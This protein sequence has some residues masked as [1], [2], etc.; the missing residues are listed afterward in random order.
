MMS[1][2]YQ[3]ILSAVNLEEIKTLLMEQ[4]VNEDDSDSVAKLVAFIIQA[5]IPE[6]QKQ[7]IIQS[8]IGIMMNK[9]LVT[10]DGFHDFIRTFPF[11]Y[12]LLF[13][14]AIKGQAEITET[15]LQMCGVRKDTNPKVRGEILSELAIFDLIENLSN[16]YAA[17]YAHH[18][19]PG[20]YE[21]RS[22]N[23]S[24][25][26]S[27]QYLIST[28]FS[29]LPR[30]SLEQGRRTIM[31]AM[32]C[33]VDNDTQQLLPILM[34][35]AGV[36][37]IEKTML[38][39]RASAD[40]FKKADF[41]PNKAFTDYV[42]SILMQILNNNDEDRIGNPDRVLFAAKIA[43]AFDLTQDSF[44]KISLARSIT[45]IAKS[46]GLEVAQ[47]TALS[48]FKLTNLTLT[49]LMVH[50][51]SIYGRIFADLNKLIIQPQVG[52]TSILEGLCA[53][54]DE[55]HE[56]VLNQDI[57]KKL[58]LIAV[59]LAGLGHVDLAQK[60]ITKFA[61]NIEEISKEQLPQ[62]IAICL[63]NG[64]KELAKQITDSFNVSQLQISIQR[65]F[66][67]CNI[68]YYNYI[69][70]PDLHISLDPFEAMV[71]FL[72]N[73]E[74]GFHSFADDDRF[75]R[76][77]DELIAYIEA[78]DS[79][80]EPINPGDNE[81]KKKLS[82]I[83]LVFIK[84]NRLDLA[85]KMIQ[86]SGL[87]MVDVLLSQKQEDQ[88]EYRRKAYPEML[89][90][91]LIKLGRTELA[92]EIMQ[93]LNITVNECLEN[94]MLGAGLD[95]YH[96]TFGYYTN[97]DNEILDSWV[98]CMDTLLK[99]P[100]NTDQKIEMG[101]ENGTGIQR[102]AE[103][104]KAKNRLDLV[105]KILNIFDATK[106]QGQPMYV[107]GNIMKPYYEKKKLQDDHKKDLHAHQLEQ[108]RLAAS[109]KFADVH[110]INAG[111]VIEKFEQ[112]V[113]LFFKHLS[114]NI[115]SNALQNEANMK[116]LIKQVDVFKDFIS[117]YNASFKNFASNPE[118]LK[119]IIDQSKLTGKT[120]MIVLDSSDEFNKDSRSILIV[121]PK[122]DNKY[123]AWYFNS[124]GLQMPDS[125]KKI[126]KECF[127]ESCTTNEVT[128]PKKDTKPK[129]PGSSGGA[130][131]SDGGD[132][133]EWERNAIAQETEA[134]K[135]DI[136]A[137]KQG[138]Q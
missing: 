23:E 126:I 117:H 16:A 59:S 94:I 65:L 127:G 43:A 93:K 134:H 83:A 90:L 39:L 62:C 21:R 40:R 77:S 108:Q 41:D 128:L 125:V 2:I 31:Q 14:S 45:F 121:E 27:L 19:H 114:E 75:K 15:L 28:I 53:A 95:K 69:A 136:I 35:M 85:D 118:S 4:G 61:L 116:S 72:G 60:L 18:E 55:N 131:A 56:Q 104:C 100:H 98:Y 8:A 49:D 129:K 17:N 34:Q 6:K 44:V 5:D 66:L 36:P 82:A 63:N 12:K 119:T 20:S 124:D 101:W 105:D 113:F 64:K 123:C 3:Q 24:Y 135:Q 25:Q 80:V 79:N 57:Q 78:L 52:F 81:A 30:Q 29:Y 99:M 111:S 138:I 70:A 133:I 115:P 73:D 10:L 96:G 9:P 74:V 1:N 97:K 102:F 88:E 137:S 86:K 46:K 47:K 106:F 110:K 32:A 103:I 42:N 58:C 71:R 33:F 120:Q 50:Y 92:T 109:K 132:E 76:P 68:A 130:L 87:S 91:I 13:T 84:I 51:F 11:F 38:E 107:I 48:I 22:Q 122:A 37:D 67:A 26:L 89:I 112:M 7:I 54:L